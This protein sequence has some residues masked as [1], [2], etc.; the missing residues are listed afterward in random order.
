MTIRILLILCLLAGSRVPATAQQAD[1][2][3]TT[4]TELLER[5]ASPDTVYVVNFWATWCVPCMQEL[6]EF[7][8]LERRYAGKPVRVLLVSLDFASDYKQ[9]IGIVLRRRAPLSEILW[10]NER[11]ANEFIPR[12]DKR[13]SGSIPATLVTYKPADLR[14]FLERQITAEELS[15]VIDAQLRKR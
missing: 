9:K 7:D 3:V 13:W 15:Q 2:P 12:I 5:T 10:L 1:V 8:I 6:P 11:D 4:V 14:L